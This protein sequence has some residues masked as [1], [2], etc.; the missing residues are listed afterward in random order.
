VP[1]IKT[2]TA[3]PMYVAPAPPPGPRDG[4]VMPGGGPAVGAAGAG[5]TARIET[6]ADRIHQRYKEIGEAENHKFGEGPPGSK[7]PDFN[8][9]VTA[10]GRV[11]PP[12][13][14]AAQKTAPATAPPKSPESATEKPGG[15]SAAP[16]ARNT[17][18][19]NSGT[20]TAKPKPQ[21]PAPSV[22]PALHSPA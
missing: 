14:S 12:G 16:P 5:N 13:S 2:V 1:D 10:D 18:R 6:D 3:G 7:P 8:V 19:Q 4:P 9:Q 17:S 15:A 22:P 11:V 21:N 20:Q